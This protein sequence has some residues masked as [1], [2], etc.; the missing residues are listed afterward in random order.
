[1]ILSVTLSYYHCQ[2]S[3]LHRSL[4]GAIPVRYLRRFRDIFAKEVPNI[5]NMRDLLQLLFL[6]KL[7][8]M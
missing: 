4:A 2:N 3:Q 8:S 6:E 7:Q 5:Q 1:M